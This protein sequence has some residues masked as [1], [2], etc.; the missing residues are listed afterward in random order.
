MNYAIVIEQAADGG[1]GGYAL[2]I[3]GI[4]VGGYTT[5]AEARESVRIA[6]EMQI[7]SLRELGVPIP[8]PT[9]VASMV[10]VFA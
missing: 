10:E 6:L 1:W 7:E 8:K 5:Q 9:S 4:A 3:P 2:D